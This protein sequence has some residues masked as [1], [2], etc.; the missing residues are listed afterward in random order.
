[1]LQKRSRLTKHDIE[2]LKHARRSKS[3]HFLAIYGYS[4]A[5]GAAKVAFSASKK[6]A[7]TAVLR[8]KLRRRGYSAV[9]PLLAQLPPKI[10]VLISYS[11]PW[12]DSPITDITAELDQAFKT[13]GL[14]K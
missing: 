3:V 1:M 10:L 5:P 7:K 2:Q 13:A 4:S 6:V 14:Y 11:S 8:N 9:A 12:T